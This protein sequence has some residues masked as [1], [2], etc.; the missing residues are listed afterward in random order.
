MIHAYFILTFC[1]SIFLTTVMAQN[2]DI[3]LK[4]DG[5]QISHKMQ[6][7]IGASWHSISK[8]PPLENDRYEFPVRTEN[9]RGSAWGGNPP[10]DN[11][12]A[13]SQLYQYAGWLGMNFLR[14][15]L[16]QRMYEPE[17][18]VY[19]WNNEEMRTLYKILDWCESS[20]AD[21]FLQQMWS[22]TSW[23]AYPGVHPLLSAPRSLEDFADG[24][25]T[26][27]N[28]LTNTKGY[29]CIKYFCITNEPP[30]GTWGYW[31]SKGKENP[32][33]TTAWKIVH[34]TFENRGI[35]IPL[36]GPDWTDL[37][38]FDATK[39]DF[40]PYIDAYDIHSY[41]GIDPEGANTVKAWSDWAHNHGKP[42]F[43]TEFG[44]MQLGWGK[45][46]PGPKT[47][48][49]ALSDASDLIT[50]LNLGVDGFNRWSFV[51]RG[52]LDGQWQLIRTWDRNNKTYYSDITPEKE[53]FYG[54]AMLTRFMKKYASILKTD[55]SDL[56]DGVK[57]AALINTDNGLT[58]I[59]LNKNSKEEQLNIM[60]QNLP[61]YEPLY[62]YQVTK[63]KINQPGFSLSPEQVE[64]NEGVKAT[65]PAKSISVISSYNLGPEKRGEI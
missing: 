11:T 6:G 57:T 1:F 61:A 17:R 44:N 8:N 59:I 47:F 41:Q 31:W 24:I 53:A 64:I 12:G 58:I 48:D 54:F 26:L 2:P 13:W 19:D 23:N 20:G 16:S 50:G 60:L 33:V 38:P 32:P 37:P 25:A 28:Y 42:F 9:S 62:L 22:Y 10:L 14:V 34:E 40:D 56:P 52:D 30:G 63:E 46:N 29:K 15:E 65:L 35:K 43:I 55:L 3:V 39:I 27:V 36:S 5:S 18:G 45:D 51:N 49:A 4:I 21:V 7:G